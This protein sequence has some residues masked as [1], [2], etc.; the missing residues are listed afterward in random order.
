MTWT[1]SQRLLSNE[2]TGTIVFFGAVITKPKLL[3]VLCN[4]IHGF[5]SYGRNRSA[6]LYLEFK[7]LYR[8]GLS[9]NMQV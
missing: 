5:I 2:E 1:V 4:K 8:N 9:S 6:S 3:L 7:V